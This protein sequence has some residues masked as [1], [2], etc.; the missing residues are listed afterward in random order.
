M[1]T[2][3]LKNVKLTTDKAGKTKIAPTPPKGQSVSRKIAE[4]KSKKQFVVSPA[5]AG[6]VK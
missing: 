3:P 1:P 4:R 2:K 5:K 6:R